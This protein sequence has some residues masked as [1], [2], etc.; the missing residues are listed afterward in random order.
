MKLDRNEDYQ[1]KIFIGGCAGRRVIQDAIIQI[2]DI[3]KNPS[4]TWRNGGT[5]LKA[6]CKQVDAFMQFPRNLRDDVSAMGKIYVADIIE[7]T[8]EGK[9][10]FYTAIK[11]TIRETVHGD[12]V[13]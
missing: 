13:A 3:Y 2:T 1:K 4:T 8:Q 10:T 5:K 9:A 7:Q 12:V 6:Y 11:G